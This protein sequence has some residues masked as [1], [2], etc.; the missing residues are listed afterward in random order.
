MKHKYNFCVLIFCGLI[1]ASLSIPFN[2]REEG[3]IEDVRE[4]EKPTLDT[5]YNGFDFITDEMNSDFI[6]SIRGQFS[7]H[8]SDEINNER[9]SNFG[10]QILQID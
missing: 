3:E 2:F 8:D 5:I 9:S 6:N 7:N 4:R 10:D 1:F